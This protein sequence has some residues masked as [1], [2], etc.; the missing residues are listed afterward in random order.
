MEIDQI[1]TK[2]GTPPLFC[3]FTDRCLDD[4]KPQ[5]L[6]LLKER[7]FEKICRSKSIPLETISWDQAK[8]VYFSID[9]DLIA[10]AYEFGLLYS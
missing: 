4:F 10:H 8:E 5:C 6:E 2:Y 1:P 9:Q 3:T 7:V